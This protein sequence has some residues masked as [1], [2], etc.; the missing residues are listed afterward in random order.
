[1]MT[2]SEQK[3][4]L[5]RKKLIEAALNLFTSHDLQEV[6]ISDITQE[7]G[8]AKGTFYLF[9]KDKYELRDV[10]ISLESEK[11]LKTALDRLEQNDIRSFP[12]AVIFMINQVLEQLTSNP[13]LLRLIKRNL[14]AGAFHRQL[15]EQN[16]IRSFP[17]AVIFMINQVLEQLTSNPL[18]LRLIKRNL[19]AGAFHRQLR[20]TAIEGKTD[21]GSRFVS[22]AEASGYHYQD[23]QL[24]FLMILEL[25]GSL[26]YSSIV[27]NLPGPI[28]QV[29]PGLFD[30]IRAILD[31]A[32]RVS[33]QSPKTE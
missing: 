6:S 25:T 16:D 5:K 17:D 11:L 1:M 10:V 24:V 7:A 3:K 32:R 13:L 15:L 21:L 26:C 12:D 30:A 31:S 28:A 20:Y 4:D 14:S 23:P 29:K 9:F 2:R 22:L 33:P 18:L 19:S 27:E 8:I